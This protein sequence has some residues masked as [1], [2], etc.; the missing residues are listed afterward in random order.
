M[1]LVQRVEVA[2]TCLQDENRADGETRNNCA[3]VTMHSLITSAVM[4][5]GAVAGGRL[6]C[7]DVGQL[8]II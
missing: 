3:M 5:K 4:L 2:A 1:V 8:F 6:Q 7:F